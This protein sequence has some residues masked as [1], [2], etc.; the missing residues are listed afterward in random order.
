[1]TRVQRLATRPLSFARE[2]QSR[3]WC[4]AALAVDPRLRGQ[5]IPVAKRKV[6]TG[7]LDVSSDLLPVR[8]LFLALVEI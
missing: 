6:R 3:T 7:E 5:P 1:M 2:C 8:D 4:R